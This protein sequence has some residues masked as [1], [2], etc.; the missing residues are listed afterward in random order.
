MAFKKNL[1]TKV[2]DVARGIKFTEEEFFTDENGQ[3]QGKYEKHDWFD[4]PSSQKGN[5]IKKKY[6]KLVWEIDDP[7]PGHPAFAYVS[8]RGFYK[9][10]K[11]DGLCVSF[12]LG[13]VTGLQIYKDGV[14]VLENQNG[15][16]RKMDE[17][18]RPVNVYKLTNQEKAFVEER[19][20]EMSENLDWF[21]SWT[22]KGDEKQV[23]NPNAY[24]SFER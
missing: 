7:V 9:N 11:K 8:E 5:E 13:E 23:M 4:T 22:N 6:S 10:G 19:L 3:K 24:K 16:W 2:L 17:H 20:K 1:K 21:S 18:S 12:Y 15:E 14:C